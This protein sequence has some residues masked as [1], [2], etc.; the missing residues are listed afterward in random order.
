[1]KNVID[2]DNYK[3]KKFMKSREFNTVFL[4]PL[5]DALKTTLYHDLISV[6][7]K[8]RELG[9]DF[10]STAISVLKQIKE[11]YNGGWQGPDSA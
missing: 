3:V 8:S 7:A 6:A 9:L 1:M 11:F 4:P 10:R 2:L 5:D